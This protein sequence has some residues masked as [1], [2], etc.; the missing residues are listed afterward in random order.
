MMA[1]WEHMTDKFL[2]SILGVPISMLSRLWPRTGWI[3][4]TTGY[5]A[6][7]RCMAMYSSGASTVPF[8]GL[9]PGWAARY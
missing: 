9:P 5:L 1:N 8:T 6:R 7:T 4:M 2:A 3:E